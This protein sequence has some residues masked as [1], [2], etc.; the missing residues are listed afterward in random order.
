MEISKEQKDWLKSQAKRED[1]EKGLKV[2][3]QALKNSA[4]NMLQ[5]INLMELCKAR[6]AELPP[7]E[8]AKAE[9][10]EKEIE[11]ATNEAG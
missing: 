5:D 8:E 2:V 7:A 11:E 9:D 1:W 4:I 3:E 10:A 6:L